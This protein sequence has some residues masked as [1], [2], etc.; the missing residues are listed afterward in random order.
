MTNRE[1]SFSTW[2]AEVSVLIS[3][4]GYSSVNFQKKWA[5]VPLLWPSKI[6]VYCVLCTVPLSFPVQQEDWR[7]EGG[8]GCSEE[9]LDP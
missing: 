6:H 9:I 4:W 3:I 5:V 8:R 1:L 7:E 2:K